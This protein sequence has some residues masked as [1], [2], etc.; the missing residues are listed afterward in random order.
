MRL[1]HYN[2]AQ[3]LRLTV[4]L[5]PPRMAEEEQFL[6]D[7]QTPGSPVFHKFLTAEQWNARFAPVAADEQRVVDWAQSQGLTVTNRFA[8]RLLVNLEAPAATI[9]N[10]LG[11]TINSYQMGDSVYYANDRDPVLPATV[12]GVVTSIQGLNNIQREHGANP[13]AEKLKG[14]D[15]ALG[16]VVS[17]GSSDQGDAV[18]SKIPGALEDANGAEPNLTNGMMDPKDLYSPQAYNYAG[19]QALGH[20]CNPNNKPNGSPPESSIAIAAFGPFSA[21]DIVGFNIAYP[22][23]AY[24]YH[25][26]NVNG[27]FQCPAGQTSCP[28]EETTQDLE[29][30]IATSNSFGS[31]ITTSHIYVYIGATQDNGTFTTLYNQMLSDGNARVLTTSWTCTEITSCSTST[32]DARH[33]IFNAMVGQGWTLIAAAGDRGATDDCNT[34]SV[35][36]PASDP[37]FIAAG[38]TELDLD[39]NA[40][41]LSETAWQGGTTTGSCAAN[42]GGSGGGVS[43]YYAQPAWQSSLSALGS[44]RLVPDLA[45]NAYGTGQNLYFNGS[46]SANA[47]GTSVV[48]PELAGFFAQENAYLL[49]I[50]N[51]CGSAGNSACAPIGN[52]GA[53]LYTAGTG[54]SRIAHDPFYDTTSGCNSNDVTTA[55]GLNFFCAGPGYDQVTGWGSANMMQLAW[56]L[57]AQVVP[58]AGSPTVSFTGPAF[59]TW[60]NSNQTVSFTINDSNPGS[61]I[62]GF[63]AGWDSI[64]ADPFSEANG[65][66]GNSFYTG[67]ANANETTG[68]LSLEAGGCSTGA[69][70]GCH[71]AHVEGWNNLGQT[72]GD[73]PYGPLCLDTVS[74]TVAFT[75]LPAPNAPGWNN[76]PVTVTLVATDPAPASGIA[77]TYYAFSAACTSTALG[78]CSSYTQPFSVAPEGYTTVV[79]FAEDEAGNFSST[80]TKTIQIDLT[81]PVTGASM[82]GTLVNGSYNAAVQITLQATDNLSKVLTTYYQL[83]GGGAVSYNATTSSPAPITV[84]ALG[85]HTFNYWSV[86]NAGNVETAHTLSFSIVSP[87]TITLA[88][89]P[90]PA[91]LGQSVTLTATVAATLSGTPTGSVAFFNGTNNLGSTSLVSGASTLVTTSLPAGQLTLQAA[92]AG[93]ANFL[94]S[95]SATIGLFVGTP[96]IGLSA[97]AL[98]FPQIQTGTSTSLPLTLTNTGAGNETVSA[99]S[100]AGANPS[101][102]SYATNCLNVAIAPNATCTMQVTFSPAAATSLAATLTL[103][104]NAVNSPQAVALS[105]ASIAPPSVGLST[106]ALNFP[107]TQLNNNNSLPLVLTNTG[108]ASLTISGLSI[109]GV[110]S[111][112]FTVGN[113]CLGIP[114]APNGSC[115]VQVTFSPTAAGSLS[116]R[117]NI[118]DNAANSP[119]SVS[120]SGIGLAP[121]GVGLSTTL[122]TFP[123]TQLNASASLPL[124]V[125]NTGGV[126][127]TVNAISVAGANPA[128]FSSGNTC[129]GVAIAPNGSC[130]LQVQFFPAAATSYSATLILTDNAASSPQTVRLSGAGILPAALSLS[131]R[132]LSFPQTQLG[133]SSALPLTLVNSGGAPL[134]VTG[135]NLA[136]TNLSNF[137]YGANCIGVP[138]AGGGSCTTQVM[139]TPAKTGTATAS[140]LIADNAANS[141]QSVSLSGSGISRPAVGLSST[142]L[143]FPPTYLKSSITLPITLTN[144][145]T[146]TLKVTSIS[147]SGSNPSDFTHTTTCIGV[148]LAPHAACTIRV[149]FTPVTAANLTASLT[150]NDNAPNSPQTIV[151]SGT[152]VQAPVAKVSPAVLGFPSTTLGTSS[153][154]PFTVSNTGLGSLMVTAMTS[155]GSHAASFFVPNSCVAVTIAP[156]GECTVQVEFTPKA[157]GNF[158]AT[159]QILD[160]ATDSPQS[161]TLKGTGH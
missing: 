145:G 157:K 140:L 153:T 14:P 22:Y 121:P 49:A 152:G 13:S 61:G 120:L 46:M 158:S 11:V 42:D 116:A 77:N 66:A 27:T 6:K 18:R 58:N 34:V 134:T 62:A 154:V 33:A 55:N 85:T 141:P 122:L 146:T 12:A 84:S 149:K 138:I 41:W 125:T 94:P 30:A 37:N 59:N 72:T 10:A 96:S 124:T 112:S 24:Q 74:P 45:L 48:A 123:P 131:T 16:P 109:S 65:G 156:N 93:S 82:T 70:Q 147:T 63:T 100:V 53:F 129:T 89:A 40:N 1:S 43:A 68:C 95:N 32:M 107:Q 126:P 136:G 5:Q 71:T 132:A 50:G 139:F 26:Y 90:S 3:K 143:S 57:N 88:A 97:T 104:D 91:V 135:L 119:Q 78:A 148:S 106:S 127:L 151:M 118:A 23:L 31:H 69:T 160:N 105:G 17:H 161:V 103:T 75:T 44:N 114:I 128:G 60:T 47:N 110:N 28:S 15:Y 2:P 137:A 9:E 38:G 79:Y 144:T 4:A 52:P 54:A 102:F 67:P 64:P 155:S 20:C 133:V 101:G 150:I 29:W 36:Y 111:A 19:L 98:T 51:K 25:V 130:T 39:G 142:T 7:L 99:I 21:G 56:A 108:G 8:N 87:T 81:P 86:D 76:A 113:S 80:A 159:M 83:D 73:T 115:T 92:F 35:A 117:L